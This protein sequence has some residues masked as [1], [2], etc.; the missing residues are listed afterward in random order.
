MYNYKQ[1]INTNYGVI[2]KKQHN[3]KKVNKLCYYFLAHIRYNL[4]CHI[5][6]FEKSNDV[7]FIDTDT[8]DN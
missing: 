6:H 4:M 1:I 3:D 5:H 2:D 8:F 7:V